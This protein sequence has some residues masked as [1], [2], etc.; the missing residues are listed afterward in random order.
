MMS[1]SIVCGRVSGTVVPDRA[2]YRFQ[3]VFHSFFSSFFS[4]S[5]TRFTVEVQNNDERMEL[6]FVGFILFRSL[7]VRSILYHNVSQ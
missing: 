5:S 2:S 6:F 1:M 3:L 7:Q 4:S